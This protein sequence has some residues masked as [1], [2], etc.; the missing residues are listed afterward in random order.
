MND[1]LQKI[2][3]IRQAMNSLAE[4]EQYL[5]EAAEAQSLMQAIFSDNPPRGR[6]HS[7]RVQITE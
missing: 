1:L 3:E 7:K 4:V 5:T 2:R 6:R